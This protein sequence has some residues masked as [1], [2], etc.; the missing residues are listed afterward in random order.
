M[1]TAASSADGKSGLS[2]ADNGRSRSR[3]PLDP[4]GRSNPHTG[5]SL[6]APHRTPLFPKSADGNPFL[7]HLRPAFRAIAEDGIKSLGRAQAEHSGSKSFILQSPMMSSGKKLSLLS[8]VAIAA[9]AAVL[10]AKKPATD[11]PQHVHAEPREP[12]AR[13][14]P[15][16]AARPTGV[17][18]VLKTHE[19]NG[20]KVPTAATPGSPDLH[21]G[22]EFSPSTAGYGRSFN[23]A[24]ALLEPRLDVTERT[25][26]SATERGPQID[27]PATTPGKPRTHVVVDGD[28]LT[29]LAAR[30]L[31]SS[32][33]YREIFD[34]NRQLLATP[35]LLPIGATL[36]IPPPAASTAFEP[37]TQESSLPNA[38]LPNANIPATNR[39][40]T[41]L[42][43]TTLV[44]VPKGALRTDED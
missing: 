11:A 5:Q 9:A 8:V 17:Q 28:T 38:N 31:G 33:R 2:G 44:P 42:P 41:G 4:F 15:A 37:V 12:L 1:A 14:L 23:P 22:L 30:Y 43:A 40:I 10:F 19:D 32:D 18:H 25:L 34:A 24:G 21:V 29:G 6:P 7:P 35:D 27:L 16:Q 13:R 36:E 20:L 39:P 3:R 26:E